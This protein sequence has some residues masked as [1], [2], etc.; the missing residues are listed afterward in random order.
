M[1]SA[2]DR[3]LPERLARFQREVLPCFELPALSQSI[4]TL[5]SDRD[6]GAEQLVAATRENPAASAWLALEWERSTGR[7][8]E[9]PRGVDYWVPRLGIERCRQAWISGQIEALW[10][11]KPSLNH[12]RRISERVDRWLGSKPGRD[13]AYADSAFLAGL[14]FDLLAMA[15]RLAT[16]STMKLVF[17]AR[18]RR[19]EGA[20]IALLEQA[21]GTPGFI[22]RRWLAGIAG[23]I[24]CGELWLQLD[25]PRLAAQMLRW[26][27]RGVPSEL[28]RLLLRRAVGFPPRVAASWIVE[29]F[30][31][32][33]PYRELVRLS[34][35]PE[36]FAAD[37]RELMQLSQL[38][39]RF[40]EP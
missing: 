16:D 27:A 40:F 12:A 36:A 18:F 13:P 22:C 8:E 29:S 32:L 10:G 24:A 26:E 25:D 5:L 33:A 37:R 17:E 3:S 23:A 11:E 1:G 15:S 30:P 39:G 38:L 7:T 2:P 31:V 4:V 19:F 6:A 14:L 35:M 34:E 28:R 20:L 9:L 21:E